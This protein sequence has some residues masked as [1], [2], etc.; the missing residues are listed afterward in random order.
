MEVY[1]DNSATTRCLPEVAALMTQLMC[2]EYGN[3]SSMHKKGV[4]SEKYVRYAKE[5]IAKCMK[6]QEKEILFTSG[7]TESDN[8]ALIGGAY[9]NYR[10]GRHIITTRIEHPAVLQTCAYLEEQ[11]F[12]VTYLPVDARGVIA[13]ADLE[14]AMTKNTILVSIMHTNNEVGSVQPIE[15]AGEL[16]K[17]MNPNT[18]FHVDAVQGFG[19]FKIYPKRMHIDLLS[20]SA[21]KIHGPKGVGFLYISEKAKVRPIIFGGGQQKGMRSGTEN[22][23]GIAGM[24]RAVEE[25]FAD[26]DAKVEYL[27]NIRER[28][29]NGVRAIDGIRINGPVGRDGAPHVVSVSIQ[30]VRSEV[31]LHALEDKGIYVSA[32][33]ACSSNKPSVS[34]TLK[35]LGVEKQYLD[36]TLRFSFSLYTTEAEIDYTIKCLNELIP[37]LR[38]YTRK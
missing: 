10:A 37:A 19:K 13:L 17:R 31:M 15:Q 5:V 25:I 33:S 36:A 7:G 34:A 3:P 11:G 29:V 8:I 22:V 27:Y 21:H 12:A 6:V 28:F 18:L 2:E 26:F 14:R 9:A 38:K 35:A 16:I 23:P 30:G 24:A 20:V 4:E 1:L 32:G